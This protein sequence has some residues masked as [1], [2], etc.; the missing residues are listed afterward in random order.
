MEI[1]NL[2]NNIYKHKKV[3]NHLRKTIALSMPA[4]L[5]LKRAFEKNSQETPKKG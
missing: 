4:H 5:M 2:N 1:K 3:S